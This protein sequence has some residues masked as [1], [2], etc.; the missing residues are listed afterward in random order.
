MKEFSNG[1]TSMLQQNQETA[2]G[3]T[4]ENL[5]A[6][7]PSA[8][9]PEPS[10]FVKRRQLNC[11]IL[12]FDLSDVVQFNISSLTAVLNIIYLLLLGSKGH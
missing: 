3:L 6:K 11:F 7:Y 9:L 8:D 4:A 5:I 10:K 1:L 12:L 2:D